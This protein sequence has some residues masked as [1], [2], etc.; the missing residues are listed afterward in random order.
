[1][2]DVDPGLVGKIYVLEDCMS[3]VVIPDVIDYTDPADEAFRRFADRGV[4]LVRSTDSLESLRGIE[5]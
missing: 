5:V 3:P 1:M 4:H 2:S